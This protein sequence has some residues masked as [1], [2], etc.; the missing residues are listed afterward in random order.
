LQPIKIPWAIKTLTKKM[1]R[2]LYDLT[3]RFSKTHAVG[4]QQ[5]VML[6]LLAQY[7]GFL[8]AEERTQQ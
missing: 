6:I 4:L 1:K 2:T 7:L 8:I 5:Q 3:H